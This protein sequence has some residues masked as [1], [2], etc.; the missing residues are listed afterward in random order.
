MV[1]FLCQKISGQVSH[2]FT[3]PKPIDPNVPKTIDLQT[4]KFRLRASVPRNEIVEV[5]DAIGPLD[6][7]GQEAAEGGSKGGKEAQG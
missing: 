5:L 3:L 2:Q 6:G 1:R 7:R 4:S